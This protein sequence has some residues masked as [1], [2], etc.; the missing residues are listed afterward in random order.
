MSDGVE[1]PAWP[2]IVEALAVVAATG[3]AWTSLRKQ[4]RDEQARRKAVDGRISV[5]A[6]QTRRTIRS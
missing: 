1:G 4:S 6:Y 5:Q 2:A 3:L